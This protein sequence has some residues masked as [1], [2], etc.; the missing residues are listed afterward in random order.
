LDRE[1][2]GPVCDAEPFFEE[3]AGK[4]RREEGHCRDDSGTEEG[5][6]G[7]NAVGDCRMCPQCIHR[8]PPMI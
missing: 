4:I 2:E 1:S 3:V 5:R 6:T 7:R 8:T